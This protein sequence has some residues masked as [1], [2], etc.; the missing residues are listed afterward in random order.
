MVAIREAVNINQRLAQL[1]PDT[2]LPGVAKNIIVMSS[3]LAGLDRHEEAAQAATQ[4]LAIL[5]PF[6]ERYPQTY[7]DMARTIAANI[8]RYSDAAG[9][10]PDNA[11]LTRLA[12]A[13][14]HRQAVEKDST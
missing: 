9:L 10:Q 5:A 13:L 6:V 8:L 12:K 4:A 11:L 1:Q 3:V 2:F 7:Q 14:G